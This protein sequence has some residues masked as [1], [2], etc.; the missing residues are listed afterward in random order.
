MWV[1]GWCCVF[2]LFLFAFLTIAGPNNPA[3]LSMTV[4]HV[5]TAPTL[6]AEESRDSHNTHHIDEKVN[7][8]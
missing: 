1:G 6:V 5:L 3:S 8:I 7:Y 2:Y 4:D